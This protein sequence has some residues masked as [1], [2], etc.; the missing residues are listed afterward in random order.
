MPNPEEAEGEGARASNIQLVIKYPSFSWEGNQYESF[1]TF[2]SRTTI[3]MEGPYRKVQEFDKVAAIL[4]WLGDKGFNLYEQIDWVGIGKNKEVYKD[5]LEAFEAHFKPCQTAMHS[6]YQLGSIYSNQCKN[7][8]EFMQRLKDVP[9]ETGFKNEIKEEIIKFLFVT[10]NTDQKVREYLLDKADPEKTSLDFL[11]LARTVE[12]LVKTENM[13]R[14]LL[15]GAGKVP[16]G[17]V[18]KQKRFQQKSKSRDRSNTPYGGGRPS[19]KP[20]KKCGQKHPPRKCPA[21]KEK[22]HKCKGMGHFARMCR[23]KNPNK[24]GYQPRQSRRE[25]YEVDRSHYPC[26]HSHCSGP[27]SDYELHEDTIQIVY[28]DTD[29]SQTHIRFDE[30]N[31]Q[32]LGELSLSNR[33][34]RSLTQMFKLDSGACAKLIPIG[35]YGKL[36]DKDDRDLKSSI[37][38]KV[39]LIAANNKVIKQLGTVNLRVKAEGRNKVCRFYVVPNICRPI[40]GLPDLKRMDLVQFKLPTTSYWSDQISSID[41]AT[42]KDMPKDSTSIYQGITKDQILSKYT[43]VFTGLGRL[44]VEPVKIHLKPGVPPQQKPCRRVPI[45]IRGKFK[46][47]LDDMEGQGTIT[48]LDK[49]TVTP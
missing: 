36:F 9:K 49:N 15:A 25:H 48:K 3:L 24:G 30:V 40:L 21:Y 26:G 13:S 38:H 32:A 34:G 41:S 37:D 23:T 10:H 28:K 17:A 39:K 12:S 47:E 4:G 42:A 14:E 7:Q 31:S 46:E 11:K 1:K 20:C 5:V 33:A 29:D 19:I 18:A 2:K 6:W 45:A 35:V 27:E 44:K 43:K 16:V 22:C 8:S